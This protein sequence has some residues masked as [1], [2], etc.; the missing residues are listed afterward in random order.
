MNYKKLKKAEL[1]EML[2]QKT[3]SI[4]ELKHK[5]FVKRTNWDNMKNEVKELQE[6]NYKLAQDADQLRL[7]KKNITNTLEVYEGRYNHLN[8]L[9][10]KQ[11][12]SIASLLDALRLMAVDN[13]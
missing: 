4:T 7:D 3:R 9:C 1:I 13:G 5:D 6:Y 2:K 10:G 8:E 11:K 12:K